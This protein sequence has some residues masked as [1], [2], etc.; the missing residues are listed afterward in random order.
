LSAIVLVTI[1]RLR[2]WRIPIEKADRLKIAGLGCLVVIGNQVTYLWGQS[3]TA[4][5]HG[6]LLFAATP[7][8]IFLMALVHLGEKFRWRRAIG[9]VIGITGV[10]I[11]MGAG[12]VK[13]GTEY[14]IGDA[15]ILFAVLVWAYYTVWGKPLA[16]KYGAMRVTAYSLASGTLLYFPFG[17]FQATQFEYSGVSLGAWLS[18]VYVAIGTSVLGYILWYWVLK[19]FEASRVAVF[20]NIQ[21]IFASIVALIFLNEPLGWSFMIGGA[22][23]LA[24]VIITEV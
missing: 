16:R 19:Y 3:M 4:A 11:V 9:V 1:V 22:V 24:G 8:F 10:A 17:L 6:A 20:Q 18:V 7:I 2:K 5:G 21:P 13:I 12:A 15:I 14:L 23:V